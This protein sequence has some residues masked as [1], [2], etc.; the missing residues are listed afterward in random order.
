VESKWTSW[1]QDSDAQ[2]MLD[3][4]VAKGRVW[5]IHHGGSSSTWYLRRE[6][7]VDE[8]LYE[9]HV[10]P[11][12]LSTPWVRLDGVAGFGR[13]YRLTLMLR[14]PTQP[15]RMSLAVVVSSDFDD[16]N[17]IASQAWTNMSLVGGSA[18]RVVPLVI[19]PSTQ[20]VG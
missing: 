18:L 2:N 10:G 15:D 6:L 3:A 8:D 14:L 7:G 16:S 11:W 4:V 17:V 9:L 20:R 13:L 19:H 1:T 12:A 5:Y